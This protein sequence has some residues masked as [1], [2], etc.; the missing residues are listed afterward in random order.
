MPL[1]AGETTRDAVIAYAKAQGVIV[2]STQL[3]R[4]HRD[5]LLPRPRQVARGKKQGTVT[6]YPEI[7]APLATFLA[8][9]IALAKKKRRRLGLD[10]LAWAA[11]LAGYPLTARIRP[12]LIERYRQHLSE[13]RHA[14]DSF[15]NEVPGNPIDSAPD[16]PL[17]LGKR[18][19]PRPFRPTMVRVMFEAMAGTF[20]P[21][22]YEAE[23]Y[24]QFLNIV[25]SKRKSPTPS[26]EDFGWLSRFMVPFDARRALDAVTRLSDKQ[27]EADR[28]L[29][30]QISSVVFP[31]PATGL[32]LR[33]ETFDLVFRARRVSPEVRWFQKWITAE[34]KRRG[35]PT[36]SAFWAHERD[37]LTAERSGQ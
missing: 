24:R 35:F 33:V 23:D 9:K 16:V 4:W 7:A 6:A 31:D 37:R 12:L 5:G 11:W 3:I 32:P 30:R 26:V 28:D 8:L 19:V 36:L 27:L 17:R 14:L 34:A 25:P 1:A 21:R 18:R 2:T 15:E 29:T 10:Q 22:R 13:A 20:E